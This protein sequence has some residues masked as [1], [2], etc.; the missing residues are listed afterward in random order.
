M[1]E[2]FSVVKEAGF[3]SQG[4][5]DELPPG[6]SPELIASLDWLRLAELARAIASNA[7]CELGGSRVFEDGSV[8]FAMFEEPKS[9]QPRRVLVKLLAWN[10]WCAT[11]QMVETFAQDVRSTR[12]ARGVLIA[13]G[14]FTPAASHAA[15]EH[16]IE[17]VDAAR[18]CGTL[19][20]MAEERSDF[21]HVITTA[22]D[23]SAPTC[24]GM[25]GA[26]VAHCQ[27][28]MF[29]RTSGRERE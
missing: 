20:S 28:G 16:H 6:W 26:W 25:L 3:S 13:P 5:G 17:P 11:P 2:P 9:A 23:F 8:L 10:D 14:G 18:L 15:A 22:G 1:L 7:G 4:E 29:G 21:F 27:N 19:K 24:P 12:D